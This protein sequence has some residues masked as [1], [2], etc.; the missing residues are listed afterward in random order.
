M[1]YIIATTF[2]IVMAPIGS[3]QE[4]DHGMGGIPDWYDP[5]CCS[6][7]DCKPVNDDRGVEFGQD[8]DGNSWARYKP[9]GNTFYRYQFKTSQDERYHVCIN[10]NAQGNNGSLCFYDRTGAL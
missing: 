2:F 6:K 9:T 1:R 7:K 3:A 10:P 4:H 5:S 8:A